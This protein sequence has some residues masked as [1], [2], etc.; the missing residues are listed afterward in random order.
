MRQ[1][2]AMWR[3]VEC[4]VSREVVPIRKDFAL[5]TPPTPPPSTAAINKTAAK[6]H[7]LEL[8]S[9]RARAGGRASIPSPVPEISPNRV[10]RCEFAALDFSTNN[11]NPSITPSASAPGP[12]STKTKTE[13]GPIKKKH[14]TA[15]THVPTVAQTRA[16]RRTLDVIPDRSLP[17]SR[18]YY[19]YKHTPVTRI[20]DLPIH[21][22][23]YCSLEMYA[24][25]RVG[26]T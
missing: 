25:F 15:A 26:P 23:Q 8:R 13:K 19:Y 12:A 14:I 2:T 4:E 16:A 11:H 3:S 21:G 17:I 1:Q 22:L 7:E 20:T 24:D 5:N 18:R 6:I 9:V 10:N